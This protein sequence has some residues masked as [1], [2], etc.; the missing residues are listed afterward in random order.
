MT[1]CVSKQTHAARGV[2]MYSISQP[3]QKDSIRYPTS[4]P[5]PAKS[6][7]DQQPE[8]KIIIVIPSSSG[9][10]MQQGVSKCTLSQPL[11]IDSIRYPTSNLQPP[12]SN[13]ITAAWEEHYHCDSLFCWQT[14]SA[15]GG[16]MYLNP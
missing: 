12:T 15:R 7:S 6:I 5:Q 4:N 3:K 11:P 8:K 2:K 10:L 16:K 13:L 9:K 14:H 1:S